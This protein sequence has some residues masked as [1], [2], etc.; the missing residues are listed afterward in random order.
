[1]EGVKVKKGKFYS[2]TG[3]EGPEESRSIA[4]LLH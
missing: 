3:R 4:L 1:V 2:R